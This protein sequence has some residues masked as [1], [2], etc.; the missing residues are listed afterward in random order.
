[1]T[2]GACSPHSQDEWRFMKPVVPSLTPLVW[3]SPLQKA[4]TWASADQTFSP[5]QQRLQQPGGSRL[6]GL[7]SQR[8]GPSLWVWEWARTRQEDWGESQIRALLGIDKR[9]IL[10]QTG[11]KILTVLQ[12]QRI[13]ISATVHKS[14]GLHQTAVKIWRRELTEYNLKITMWDLIF[15]W[16]L[17]DNYS[18]H[19]ELHFQVMKPLIALLSVCVCAFTS[20]ALP[21][22][23]ETFLLEDLPEAVDDSAVWRLACSSRHLEPGLDDISRGHQWSCRY[24]L[25]DVSQQT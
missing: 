13:T 25:G 24:T 17:L 3:L 15:L 10:V 23:P 14:P 20:C 1:M 21:K 7:Q 9:S 18:H 16:C 11:L 2:G 6:R 19:S 12:S 5:H 22:C 8:E 4:W